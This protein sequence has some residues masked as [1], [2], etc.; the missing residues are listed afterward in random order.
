[1]CCHFFDSFSFLN[2]NCEGWGPVTSLPCVPLN[3]NNLSILCK[4]DNSN[5]ELKSKEEIFTK[6]KMC[7]ITV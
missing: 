4:R 2:R 1:M 6:E 3:Q 7:F 5:T